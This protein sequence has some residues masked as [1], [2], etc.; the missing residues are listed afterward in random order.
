MATH[1]GADVRPSTLER[2]ADI[3]PAWIEGVLRAAG[4]DG[5]SVSAVA[6]EPIGAG[7]S[8]ETMR[9]LIDYHSNSTDAP[10]SVV[11][12]FHP[13]EDDVRMGMAAGGTFDR[14]IGSVRAIDARKACRIPKPYFLAL[15]A[16]VVR[17]FCRV[18]PTKWRNLSA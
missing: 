2:L 7:N 18:S 10:S 6:L 17:H 12:K 4:L 5:L 16:I 9:V 8:S 11:C 3:S 1:S 14:E 13:D 15:E